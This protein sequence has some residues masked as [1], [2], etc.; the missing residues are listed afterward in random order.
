MVS[1]HNDVGGIDVLLQAGKLTV[2]ADRLTGLGMAPDPQFVGGKPVDGGVKYV[3]LEELYID[4]GTGNNQVTIVDT[5]SGA[6]TINA[7]RGEDAID[8]L[9]VSGHTYINAGP[10]ADKITV[11]DESLVEGINALVT[12]T[13][14]VPRVQVI[15]LGKG[16]PA[17]PTMH[18]DAAN[19]IQQFTVEAT[20]GT[21]RLGFT[22]PGDLTD[23]EF[24]GDLAWDAPAA[25]V[26]SALEGLTHI[27]PGDVKVEKFGPVYRVSYL[28]NLAAKDIPL[29]SVND[30]G[31]TAQ[32]PI[33][34]LVVD[35]SAETEDS[36]ALLTSS[37]ISGL[38]MTS[39]NEVQTLRVD[40]TGGTFRIDYIRRRRDRDGQEGSPG[41]NEARN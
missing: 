15:T 12:V 24:T 36:L 3:G 34:T 30:L 1:F 4:L 22:N 41:Q 7:G 14:D 31:L 10:D 39:V 19:E 8:V 2:E 33:D 21:F 16:S 26:Q 9:A 20:G 11:T 23:T 17:D 27:V 40:A 38:G 35:D 18:V 25:T 5:H 6:T 29:L 37:S 28:N 13:G 32:G